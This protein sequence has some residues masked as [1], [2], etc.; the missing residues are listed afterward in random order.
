VRRPGMVQ[1]NRRWYVSAR[2]VRSRTLDQ[3]VHALSASAMNI[4]PGDGVTLSGQVTPSHRGQRIL[5]AR[6]AGTTWRTIARPRLG[7]GSR[8]TVG[9]RF[10]LASSVELR[11]VL[12]GDGRNIRSYSPT[13]TVVVGPVGIHKIKH[14]VII[15]Q[16]NRSFDQYFGTY[17]GAAGIPTGVCVRDPKNGGCIMPTTTRTIST[18]AAPTVPSTRPP[19]PTAARWTGSWPGGAWQ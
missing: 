12:P 11:A 5:L 1:T 18:T 13:I 4:N 16:E 6:R 10:T 8:Y 19:T 3:R 15:M 17:P 9:L 2:D 7:R 14:V